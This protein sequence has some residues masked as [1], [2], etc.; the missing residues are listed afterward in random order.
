MLKRSCLT[1]SKFVTSYWHK[2]I[3]KSVNFHTCNAHNFTWMYQLFY[4]SFLEFS[5]RS[6]LLS[7]IELCWSFDMIINSSMKST[8][9]EIQST[10]WIEMIS[11]VFHSISK[12]NYSICGHQTTLSQ[13]LDMSVSYYNRFCSSLVE[14]SPLCYNRL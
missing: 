13:T 8:K 4:K 2:V 9:I 1:K 6:V 12:E 14:T 5:F 10:K 7:E 11:H 3:K